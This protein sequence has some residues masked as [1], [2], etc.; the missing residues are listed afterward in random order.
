MSTR[1]DLQPSSGLRD[2]L[3]PDAMSR[4]A[5]MNAIASVFER[6][7]FLTIDTPSMEKMDVLTGGDPLLLSTRRLSAILG[8]SRTACFTW[9]L[10]PNHL[11][12]LLNSGL[13][14]H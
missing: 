6:S 12:L 1:I 13:K 4:Q 3:P 10:M 2:Y 9:A 5:M 7:G 8:E 11:H 14:P